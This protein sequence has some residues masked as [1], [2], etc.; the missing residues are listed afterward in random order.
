MGADCDSDPIPFQWLTTEPKLCKAVKFIDID[1]DALMESKRDIVLN[2]PELHDLFTVR[3]PPS[4]KCNVMF[5]SDQYSIVGCDLKNLK[6]L[7]ELIRA[8]VD[9]EKCLVLCVAE[10]SI[11][12]MATVDADGV[13]AWCTRLSSGE[14]RIGRSKVVC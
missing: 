2:T 6:R 1:Y 11:T 4:S 5:H 9:V 8:V 12:Y 13:L 10:V 7:K 3:D 14:C